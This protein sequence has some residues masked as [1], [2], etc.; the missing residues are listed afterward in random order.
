M[1]APVRPFGKD[2]DHY[3]DHGGTAVEAFG[4]F[5]LLHVDVAG[6]DALEPGIAGLRGFHRTQ[7]VVAKLNPKNQF[8]SSSR[9]PGVGSVQELL[10]GSWAPVLATDPF[11]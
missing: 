3:A 8:F 10:A 5:E 7:A 6:S 2:S 1:P 4:L 11:I 9:S